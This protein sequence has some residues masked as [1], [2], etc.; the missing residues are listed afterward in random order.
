MTMGFCLC[1]TVYM[2]AC[3]REKERKLNYHVKLDYNLNASLRNIVTFAFCCVT[4]NAHC[5][6]IWKST[7]F[8]NMEIKHFVYLHP[9]GFISRYPAVWLLTLRCRL[10]VTT[11]LI[12]LH[13][14]EIVLRSLWEAST[15][16]P[17][18]SHTEYTST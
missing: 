1:L 10:F 16:C 8:L 11:P 5:Y 4:K 3:V 12:S 17:S 9:T 15:H 2:H 7:L 6:L 13:F 14:H 18:Y